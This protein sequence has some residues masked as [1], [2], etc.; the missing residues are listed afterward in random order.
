[1][2]LS[3]AGELRANERPCFTE[4]VTSLRLAPEVILWLPHGHSHM[5]PPAPTHT[6]VDRNQSKSCFS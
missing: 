6:H 5:H 4:V 3:P 2:D 1:M